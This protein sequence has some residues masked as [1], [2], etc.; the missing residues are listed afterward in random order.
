MRR[1]LP[2]FVVALVLGFIETPIASA[3]QSV[4]L[5]IGGF[6]PRSFDG[7]GTDDVLFQNGAFLSSLNRANGI[8]I[9]QFNGVTVGGEYLVGLG[10]F[11]EGGLGISFY[12]KTTPTVYTDFV[13]ADGSDISQ[14]LKLRIV[15]LTATVRLLPLGHKSP[16]QPYVGAGVGVF[17]WRYSE[18][19]QFLDTNNVAFIGNF[20]GSGSKVG[21]V[22]LGGLRFGIGQVTAG[23]EIRWQGAK[24]NL[25][26]DQGF[27]TA[28]GSLQPKIDLGGVNYLFTLGF[29]F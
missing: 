7:R 20:T 27:A 5:F 25:P 2:L 18:T 26:T 17:L 1:L 14:D 11:L 3:Q 4:N 19:G 23:G 15:P 21:P 12:Q 16:I 24:A 22:V 8:D 6:T 13:N 28:P 29:R 9:G 10:P